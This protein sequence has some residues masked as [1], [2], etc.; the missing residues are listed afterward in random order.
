M[1]KFSSEDSFASDLESP[2]FTYNSNLLEK[3]TTIRYSGRI[4]K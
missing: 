4:N 2:F 3:K 1:A